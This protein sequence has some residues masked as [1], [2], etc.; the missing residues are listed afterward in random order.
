MTATQLDQT[1]E[2][3]R[4]RVDQ[5]VLRGSVAGLFAGLFFILANMLFATAHGKPAIAPFL[6]IS[7][8]FYRSKMPM[9]T[10]EAVVA[11]LTLHLFMS[12][13]FGI[14]FALAV[15][16][17][18]RNTAALL[19]GSLVFGLLLYVVNFQILGR[20]FFPFFLNPKG[21]NQGFELWIHPVAYGLFLVPFF[22]G[23]TG[24]GRARRAA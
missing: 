8:I 4:L 5:L 24:L 6:S 21:P 23:V 14:V 9:M 16:P 11:G 1:A 17:F 13:V 3:P 7:T 19:V 22:L 10:P 2:G 20:L 15:L 18:L 12:M